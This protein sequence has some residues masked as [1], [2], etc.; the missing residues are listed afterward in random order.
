MKAAMMLLKEKTK[1]TKVGTAAGGSPIFSIAGCKSAKKNMVEAASPS[2]IS[3]D[4]HLSTA[5]VMR[6]TEKLLGAIR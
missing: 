6:K 1:F 3:Y 5:I 4:C 2:V